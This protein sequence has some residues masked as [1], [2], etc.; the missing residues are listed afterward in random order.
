MASPP[1]SAQLRD[2]L[3]DLQQARL[4][5]LAALH[6]ATD[7]NLHAT[8][9]AAIKRTLFHNKVTMNA[10]GAIARTLER[11]PDPSLL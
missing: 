5:L 2:A 6:S 8:Y 7:Q 4:A 3:D 1:V 9:T 10:V 11:Q